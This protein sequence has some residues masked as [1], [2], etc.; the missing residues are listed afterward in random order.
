MAVFTGCVVAALLA[1]GGGRGASW[2]SAPNAAVRTG[3]ERQDNVALLYVHPMKSGGTSVRHAMYKLNPDFTHAGS[4]FCYSSVRDGPRVESPAF[5][6]ANKRLYFE[7]HCNPYEH[8]ID[9]STV[10]ETR[11]MLEA[12]GFKVFSAI[13]LRD[14]VT[15]MPSYYNHFG[16][17]HPGRRLELLLNTTL[18]DWVRARFNFVLCTIWGLR[19]ACQFPFSI[20]PQLQARAE[21]A[22]ASGGDELPWPVR[23][24]LHRA[25]L[26]AGE[27]GFITSAHA[28]DNARELLRGGYPPILGR[29]LAEYLRTLERELG[30]FTPKCGVRPLIP[31]KEEATLA[32]DD[33][34]YHFCQQ[35]SYHALLRVQG[36]W[37]RYL[38]AV[39]EADGGS[40]DAAVA[41]MN[42]VLRKLDLVGM[43]ERWD[44]SFLFMARNLGIARFP[45]TIVNVFRPSTRQSRR[46]AELRAEIAAR[47]PCAVRI[48]EHWQAVFAQRVER[49]GAKFNATLQRLLARP[50]VTMISHE[51]QRLSFWRRPQVQSSQQLA[52][53][54]GAPLDDSRQEIERRHAARLQHSREEVERRQALRL[55][56]RRERDARAGVGSAWR[57][58]GPP[59]QGGTAG[60]HPGLESETA[61]KIALP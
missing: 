48:Y 45:R 49:Q 29:L 28:R 7:F 50:A 56:R 52:S 36:A 3:F 53:A 11:A 6:R 23:E 35:G 1:V 20:A 38:R 22:R 4:N 24:T 21:E 57:R 39:H 13:T 37:A 10:D 59:L 58:H 46:A 18:D 47:E 26:H 8:L 17:G 60:P 40:C 42:A 51:R 27:G 14:P 32:V 12:R 44:E 43:C 31:G 5:L 19:E 34:S 2:R 61:G 15:T 25:T 55:Q 30:R 33:A 9:N 41:R 54:V 16:P